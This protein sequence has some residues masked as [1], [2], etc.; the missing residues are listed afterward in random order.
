MCW[1][2]FNLICSCKWNIAT[3][4]ETH[5]VTFM[6]QRSVVTE[7][8]PAKRGGSEERRRRTQHT[9]VAGKETGK[10]SETAAEDKDHRRGADNESE[11]VNGGV[12]NLHP[13]FPPLSLLMLSGTGWALC[14]HHMSHLSLLLQRRALSPASLTCTHQQ[15]HPAHVTYAQRKEELELRSNLFKTMHTIHPKET[16]CVNV[17]K[18]KG[19]KSEK[20]TRYDLRR[21]FEVSVKCLFIFESDRIR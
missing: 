11:G 8:E 3:L 20:P 1:F 12:G 17:V 19:S 6:S 16:A 14:G 4:R 15:A 18:V 9:Y 2:I 10:W 21:L 13:P 5:R 7:R